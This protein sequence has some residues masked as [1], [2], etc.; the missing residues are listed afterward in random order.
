MVS[1]YG[2]ASKS[3]TS[4]SARS[5]ERMGW[6]DVEIDADAIVES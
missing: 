4:A 6:T 1:D 5:A 2:T 3:L